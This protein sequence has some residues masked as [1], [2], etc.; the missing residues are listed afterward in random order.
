MVT[1]GKWDY[2]CVLHNYT[3]F[4]YLCI[5]STCAIGIACFHLVEKEKASQ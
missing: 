1:S 2:M 5:V 4:A 3:S